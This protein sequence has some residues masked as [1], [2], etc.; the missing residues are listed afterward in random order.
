MLHLRLFGETTVTD[1]S[2]RAL[3]IDLGAAK[4]RQVLEMLALGSGPLSKE[5]IADLLWD[6]DPPRSYRGTLQSYVCLL[7]R[8]LAQGDGG[9]S[10]IRTVMHGYVL[11]TDLVTTDVSQFRT[12]ARSAS[13]AANAEEA[14]PLVRRA[15]GLVGGELL[16]SESFAGWAAREREQFTLELA[17]LATAGARA[18]LATGAA[19]EAVQMA[20]RAL[21]QDALGE[22][23]CRILMRALASSGRRGEAVKTY[24]RLRDDL[25]VELGV[26]PSVETRALYVEILGSDGPARSAAGAAGD[27]LSILIDL[28]RQAV[29]A[30]PGRAQVTLGHALDQV[31]A[32]LALAG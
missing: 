30:M 7:R 3:G 9:G 22:E 20:R 4:P 32:D 29:G 28:V 21:S 27:E 16:A 8:G 18:A 13:Q 14:L 10:A 26:A 23:A 12:L 11:D 31:V 6:E 5:R 17:A 15:L 25:R 1:A 24:L 19:D 2:G